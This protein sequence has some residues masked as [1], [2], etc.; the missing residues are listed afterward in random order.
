MSSD[1]NRNRS[2]AMARRGLLL[3]LV[4]PSGAGKTAI[5][6][7]LLDHDPQVSL[8]IS[9]TTRPARVGE[10]DGV[11]YHFVDEDSFDHALARGDLLEHANVHGK[12]YG[13]PRGPVEAA[14]ASGRD[15]LF[16][17]DWQGAEQVRQALPDDAVTVFILPPDAA[18]LIA[19]LE[20]RGTETPERI[21]RRLQTALEELP[22]AA[23]CD[24]AIVNEDLDHAIGDVFAIL[25]SERARC[26]RCTGLEGLLDRITA[27]ISGTLDT[28]D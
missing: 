2:G 12:R 4:A 3:I 26:R 22:Y 16:D 24:Y 7:A 6:R 18:A 20:A 27:D 13:T 9:M 14:L 1:A 10:L 11:H 15:V 28:S 25:R 17:I 23:R 21:R 19:R 8:S 5:S